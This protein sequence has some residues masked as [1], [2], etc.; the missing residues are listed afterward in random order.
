[1]TDN[2]GGDNNRRSPSRQLAG[3]DAARWQRL[4]WSRRVR[5]WDQRASPALGSVTAVV[6]NAATVQ[7]GQVVLDLGCGTGQISLPIAARGAEVLAIDVSPAMADQL[8]SEASPAAL[9]GARVRRR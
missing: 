3:P 7:A 9:R 1:M 8:R 4:V 5:T 6:L 2:S